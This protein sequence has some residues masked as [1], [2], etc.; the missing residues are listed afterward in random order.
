MVGRTLESVYEAVDESIM[1][2]LWKSP[3]NVELPPH[4]QGSYQGLKATTQI[5]HQLTL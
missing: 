2:A 1:S 3:R 4:S 5:P